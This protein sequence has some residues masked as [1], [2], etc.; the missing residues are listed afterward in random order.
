MKF[1]YQARN[2]EGAIKQGTVVASDQ[3]KAESLLAENGLVIVSLEMREENILDRLNPFD[4]FI[5][6]KDLVLFS[7]QLATLIGARVPLLQSL[8]I[9]QAQITSKRLAVVTTDIIASI[10]NGESLSLALSKHPTV[11]G[12]VYIS[13]VKSGEVS[14]TLNRSLNYLADQLEKDYALK[15]K[16][17][18]ALT[19]PV[20]IIVTLVGV[21]LLMFK[22][23]LPKLTEVLTEQGGELPAVSKALIAITNFINVYW[24]LVL[25]GL[26]AAFVMARFYVGTPNG[27]Y[28]WD[29]LKISFPILSGIFQRIY[30]A[31][32]ARNLATL[33]AGGIPIIQALQII[34]EIIN[35]VIY[36]DIVMKA[37]VQLANGRSISDSLQ[38]HPEFPP[39]VTQMVRV[40]E[41]TAQL[42]DILTKLAEFYEK[43]VDDRVAILTTLLEPMIMIILGVGV[44]ALIAGIL[45]PIYNLA[46]TIG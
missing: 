34:S 3:Q 15:S 16:V 43:E 24:W 4:K 27:R 11:F 46:S 36:R 45:L 25:V 32:F 26:G 12:N 40:G 28:T 19:Y 41:E 2:K 14:G 13:L 37:S 22:F 35:N 44:G 29:R 18:S 30:L 42:D 6:G 31:R 17:R 7:R 38:G 8:R 9:L 20:F 1:Y 39:I 10:E 21:A 33:V 5:S 23:V